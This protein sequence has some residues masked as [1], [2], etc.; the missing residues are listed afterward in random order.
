MKFYFQQLAPEMDWREAK[1]TLWRSVDVFGKEGSPEK[2][3]AIR[4][5]ILG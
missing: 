5:Q 4:I 2:E 3:A 1:A